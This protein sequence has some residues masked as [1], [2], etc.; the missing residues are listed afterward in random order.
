MTANKN[1]SSTGNISI[2]GNVIA[3]ALGTG[4]NINQTINYGVALPDE[5][6]SALLDIK[7]ALE[8]L[9]LPRD[10]TQPNMADVIAAAETTPSDHERIGTALTA[11]LKVARNSADFA[12]ATARLF[13]S[14]K[15]VAEWLGGSWSSLIGLLG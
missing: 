7:I 6:H 12:D 2:G 8:A 3:S 5:I 9:Q 10:V 4:S 14:V 15:R 13:P 1:G 11:A